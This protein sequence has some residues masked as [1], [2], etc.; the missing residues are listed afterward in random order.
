M[1]IH[2]RV[3]WADQVWGILGEVRVTVFKEDGEMVTGIL[4]DNR[5]FNGLRLF[6]VYGEVVLIPEDEVES[7]AVW[8]N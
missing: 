5:D 3:K 2:L 8:A 1:H 4:L 6:T 7:V